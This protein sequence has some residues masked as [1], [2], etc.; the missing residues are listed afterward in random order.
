M[1]TLDFWRES[2]RWSL[3]G[4]DRRLCAVLED[5]RNTVDWRDAEACCEVHV[6]WRDQRVPS[7]LDARAWC[8]VSG[9]LRGQC[10]PSRVDHGAHRSLY[11]RLILLNIVEILWAYDSTLEN[12]F[13]LVPS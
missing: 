8:D 4:L 5:L 1:F 3:E 7:R 9:F 6:F 11:L 2:V 13:G 12:L 10:E